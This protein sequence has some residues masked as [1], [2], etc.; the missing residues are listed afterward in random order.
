MPLTV[1]ALPE[2][3]IWA[4]PVADTR[5][6]LSTV[7]LRSG[8]TGLAIDAG[9]GADFPF[10]ELT[11]PAVS[12]QVGLMA[13]AFMQFG[14]GGELT[15][16]LQT[17]DG[18]FG[19]PVDVRHGPWAARAAWVHLSAHYGDGIRKSGA[20]PDNLDPYSREFVALAGSRDLVLPNRLESRVYVGGRALLHA[21][22]AAAPLEVQLGGEASG[23][24]RIAPYLA[25][26]VQLAQEY[27]WSP[28]LTGQVGVR[29]LEKASR[30]RLAL[31][32]RTGPDE[33]GKT[34]GVQE[35]WV[36]L[37]FGFDR[38]GLAL[39]GAR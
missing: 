26:D 38:T 37:L 1:T 6:P 20:H 8:G 29:W 22:P 28:D 4:L 21:L 16:D 36:G 39:T 25:V 19:L 35:S 32:A 12:M 18:E 24:W 13:G 9:L 30:L 7:L 34:A 27:A 14:A 33:T 10:V 2:Q 3:T 11:S 15:F 17:F 5:S 23:P 31:A